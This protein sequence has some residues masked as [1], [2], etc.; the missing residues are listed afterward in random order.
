MNT[1]VKLR[2]NDGL[3]LWND[4]DRMVD[5]LFKDMPY[6]DTNLPSV[7]VRE[8]EDKYIIE[9]DLPGLNEKEIDVKTEKGLLTVSSRKDEKKEEK[10]GEYLIRERRSSSFSRSFRLPEDVDKEKIEASYRNGV[11]TL[12]LPK[13]AEVKPKSINVKVK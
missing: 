2:R 8:E 11:L 12:E 1:L 9:A 5:S 10:K 3:S 4:F 13:R 7:D 6:W